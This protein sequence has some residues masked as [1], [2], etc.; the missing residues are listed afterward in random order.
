M[1]FPDL[2]DGGVSVAVTVN[3]VLQGRKAAAQLVTDVFAHYGYAPTWTRIPLRVTIEAGRLLAESKMAASLLQQLLKDGSSE[4][5]QG[6][7]GAGCAPAL[8]CNCLS[9]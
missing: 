4:R 9:G 8:S 1:H 3:N 6:R 7:C 2:A 5:Q